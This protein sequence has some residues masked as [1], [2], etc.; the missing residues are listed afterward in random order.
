MIQKP[1]LLQSAA[2]EERQIQSQHAN[3]QR[4]TLQHCTCRTRVKYRP[5]RKSMLA[6]WS[7]A[8]FSSFLTHHRDCMLSRESRETK[9]FGLRISFS[10]PLL[11]GAIQA[12]MSMT[13]YS[14]GFSLSPAL[15]FNYVVS[16]DSGPFKLLNYSFRCDLI[17]AADARAALD[18][19]RQALNRI[20]REGNASPGDV[21]ENG[22]TVM[23]VSFGCE[24]FVRFEKPSNS[25]RKHSRYSM[26]YGLLLLQRS[27]T[28]LR[29]TFS[30]CETSGSL[31][32]RLTAQTQKACMGF[33]FEFEFLGSFWL[34]RK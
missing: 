12:A 10:G 32:F 34:T 1:S 9:Q 4:Q 3:P 14:G 28:Y 25:I 7:A 33:E 29:Y 26:I 17:S 23:H 13:R 18:F 2:D 19:Q 22:N 24:I 8:S 31:A 6:P 20:Y 30:L 16:S 11:Q 15:T 27:A 21:D 5:W